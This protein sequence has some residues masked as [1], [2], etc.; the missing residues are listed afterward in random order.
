MYLIL[1]KIPTHLNLNHRCGFKQ[2]T[3]VYL[4]KMKHLRSVMLPPNSRLAKYDRSAREVYY[5][6]RSTYF[7]GILILSFK[8]FLH[9]GFNC[10]S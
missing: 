7:Q 4:D 2:C 3:L 9:Y 8:E 10:M 1:L 6:V 5:I